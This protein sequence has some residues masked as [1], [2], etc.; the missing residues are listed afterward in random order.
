MSNEYFI[1]QR[2]N[3]TIKAYDIHECKENRQEA[4]QRIIGKADRLFIHSS[5][6]PFRSR[7]CYKNIPHCA[8]NMVHFVVAYNSARL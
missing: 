8:S 4:Q 5:I 7:G 3:K 6:H 2:Q 1:I